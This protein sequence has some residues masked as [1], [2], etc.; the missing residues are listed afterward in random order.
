MGRIRCDLM[1]VDMD[2]LV[3]EDVALEVD[4][5]V[6]KV[7]TRPPCPHPHPLPAACGSGCS[8]QLLL[9]HMSALHATMLPEIMTSA[10]ET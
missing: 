4:F 10:S 8:T 5:E 6:S 1:E 7:H 2:G 9:Q 3:G